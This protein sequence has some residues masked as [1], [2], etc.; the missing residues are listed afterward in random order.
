MLTIWRSSKATDKKHYIKRGV[1]CYA[2][3]RIYP[4][5]QTVNQLQSQQ[6]EHTRA[7]E[8]TIGFLSLLS[9][10]SGLKSLAESPDPCAKNNNTLM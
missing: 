6:H 5:R 4:H 2:G 9:N 7:L 3:Y 10:S 1:F 8:Y